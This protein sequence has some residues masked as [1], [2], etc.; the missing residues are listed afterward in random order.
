MKIRWTANAL[1]DI[2]DLHGYIAADNPEA[3][4]ATVRHIVNAIDALETHPGSGREGRVA[5]TRELV[6]TPYIVAYR[7]HDTAVEILGIIH[8]AR[9]W[10]DSF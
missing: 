2:E 5:G 10:P 4:S 9:R 6:I 3:A 8:G 1:Q 7:C